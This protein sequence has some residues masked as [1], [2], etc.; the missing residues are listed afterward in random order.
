MIVIET[1][2]ILGFLAGLLMIAL[3]A[4]PL[5]A[6]GAGGVAVASCFGIGMGAAAYVKKQDA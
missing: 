3:G 5:T 2:V 6:V 4:S 1:S